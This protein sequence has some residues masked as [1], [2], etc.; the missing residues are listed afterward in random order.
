[1]PGDIKQWVDDHRNCEDIAM[2]FLVANVTGNAPIKVTPRK[3][4]TC[5]ECANAEMLSAD[6]AH[7]A[8]RSECINRFVENYGTM[9]LKTVEFRA[10][11][12]LYKDNFPEKLKRFNGVGSL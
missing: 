5:L 11:P 8:Q 4:F 3:K 9:T 2:N 1:M 12:V 7:M 6:V 10:D